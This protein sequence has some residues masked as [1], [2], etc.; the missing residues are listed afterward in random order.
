LING[1]LLISTFG[2]FSVPGLSGADEDIIEFTP[3]STGDKTA[4]TFSSTLF[5]R[6]STY[7]L[8][9]NDLFAIDLP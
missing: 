5:F 9:G 3:S 4:G 2:N 6:G 7:G 1:H 8:G